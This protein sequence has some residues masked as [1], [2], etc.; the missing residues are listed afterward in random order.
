MPESESREAV[1][2][3]RQPYQ[4]LQVGMDGNGGATSLGV[5]EPFWAP[6]PPSQGGHPFREG[7]LWAQSIWENQHPQHRLRPPPEVFVTQRG[8]VTGLQPRGW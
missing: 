3:D 8:S 5:P 7:R 1:L 6:C 2:A 4:G